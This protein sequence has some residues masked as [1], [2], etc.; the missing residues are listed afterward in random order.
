MTELQWLIK[1]L[2]GQKMPQSMK[3]LF[4]ER[5]GEVE[6]QLTRPNMRIPPNPIGVPI[7]AP[8]MQKIINEAAHELQPGIPPIPPRTLVPQEVI[9]GKG[10]GTFTKGPKKW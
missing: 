7:Q 8:S 4:I 1:M 3:D 2:T 9:T 5:L 6:A 10:N